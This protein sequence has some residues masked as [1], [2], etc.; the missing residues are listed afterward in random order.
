MIS[1]ACVLSHPSPRSSHLGSL[2]WRVTVHPPVW[3]TSHP[4]PTALLPD[5][6]HFLLGSDLS[7]RQLRLMVQDMQVQLDDG[8]EPQ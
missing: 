5:A 8:S 1:V 2:S 4:P 7:G 6:Q 3:L